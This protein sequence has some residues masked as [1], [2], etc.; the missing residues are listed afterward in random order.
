MREALLEAFEGDEAVAVAVP[1]IVLAGA[2]QLLGALFGG[3]DLCAAAASGP[4]TLRTER[5]RT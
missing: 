5:R 1:V 3:V 4:G 2:A